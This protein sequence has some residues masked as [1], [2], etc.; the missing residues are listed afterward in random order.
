MRRRLAFTS[1]ILM[2]VGSVAGEEPDPRIAEA[3]ERT[4]EAATH[5]EFRLPSEPTQRLEFQSKSLLHWSNPVIGV[6]YGNVFVWT[7]QEHGRPEVIGSILQWYEP[8]KHGTHEFH[9][10]SKGPVEGS[11]DGQPVWST[12]APGIEWMP[13]PNAP[14]VGDSPLV[15]LPQMRSIV[16]G[17]SVTSTSKDGLPYNLRLLSQPLYRYCHEDSEVVDG[18]LFTFVQGTDPEVIVLVEARAD[19]TGTTRWQF[20]MVRM[21]A[22]EFVAEFQDREIWRVDAMPYA[23]AMS[24]R[25]PYSLFRFRPRRTTAQ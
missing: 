11:R 25:E 9:S 13:I 12:D 18:A 6:I 20:A 19:D 2:V 21:A 5:Y 24:G 16:R 22:L 1:L 10:L 14:E 15:R 7:Q 8:H 23:I 4:T 17:L 3:L